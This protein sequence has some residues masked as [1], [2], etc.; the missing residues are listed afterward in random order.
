M[1]ATTLLVWDI[2]LTFEQE[3]LQE[4]SLLP[5]LIYLGDADNESVANAE[6]V[7][8]DFVPNR[9]CHRSSIFL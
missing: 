7:R 9:S 4:L 3:V 6:V 5:D 2:L 1:A 8:K